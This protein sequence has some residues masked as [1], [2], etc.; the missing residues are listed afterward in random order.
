MD[1]AV[2]STKSYDIESNIPSG[3]ELNVFNSE[4]S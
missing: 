1:K 4:D 3:M 2:G